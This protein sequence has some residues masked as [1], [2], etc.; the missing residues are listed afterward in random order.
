M[1]PAKPQTPAV[2][3]HHTSDGGLELGVT[4]DKVFVPLLTVDRGRLGQLVES[5]QQL[6]DR[7]GDDE[8]AEV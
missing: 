1:P 3:A 6:A 5:A 7:T 2:S 4:L 8:G